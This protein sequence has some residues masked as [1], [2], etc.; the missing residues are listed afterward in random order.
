MNVPARYWLP[1]ILAILLTIIL[2]AVFLWQIRT[3]VALVEGTLTLREKGQAFLQ[4]LT[5]PVAPRNTLEED[6]Q[7]LRL[8]RQGEMLAAQGDA[9]KAQEALEESVSLGGGVPALRTLAQV[10]MQR[11][12]FSAAGRTIGRLEREGANAGDVVLLRGLL[13]LR[14]G[15]VQRARSIFTDVAATAQGS[16]GLGLAA[17]AVGE[18]ETARQHLQSAAQ[19]A[20][21]LI[22][23]S[24]RILLSA[25]D[26]FALFED[27]RDIHLTT[28][29][30]RALAQVGECETALPLLTH[31]ITSTNDYRDAWIVR[32]YCE[33]ISERFTDALTSLEQAYN[34]DPEKPETQYFLARAHFMLGDPQ[35]AVTFLQYA[36]VNGFE[37]QKEA[38][39]LLARYALELGDTTLALDQY[40]ALTESPG[41][42]VS[43][44]RRYV[45]LALAMNG[46]EEDAYAVALTA[47]SR[48]PDDPEALTLL[49]MTEAR[50]GRMAEAE[51]HL[52][53][54][55]RIS[56]TYGPAREEL[57]RLRAGRAAE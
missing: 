50:T 4:S 31:V 25:Y 14:S 37:P 39:L 30:A 42:D 20:D 27:G 51:R 19:G 26:E 46:R 47:E 54:A 53:E 33:L 43:A 18:H 2:G 3:S 56:P 10:E 49:A 29:L 57:Q 36:V 45:E 5:V 12:D 7:A 21:P 55:L 9:A 22:R 38:R 52:E 23:S 11:R 32:G 16:Y 24:A 1:A 8:L 44:F 40:L 35:N 28:L 41:A 15:N 34:I 13:E 48:W 17:I 6:T